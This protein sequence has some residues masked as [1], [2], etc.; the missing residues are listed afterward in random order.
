MITIPMDFLILILGGLLSILAWIG[1]R[2]HVKLDSL[3]ET[4]STKLTEVNKTLTLIDRDLREDLSKI[5]HRVSKIETT[6]KIN[7]PDTHGLGNGDL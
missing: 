3:Q 2:V 6:I 4:I 5:E 7:H 1:Q